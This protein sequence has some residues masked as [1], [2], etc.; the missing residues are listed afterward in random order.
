MM[1]SV[2]ALLAAPITALQATNPRTSNPFEADK[3]LLMQA[4]RACRMHQGAVYFIQHSRLD[5]PMIHT[6]RALGDTDAQINCVLQRLP[7]HFI[8][9][10][11]VD[12][13][14]APPPPKAREAA[15]DEQGRRGLHR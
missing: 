13:E 2:L 6:T 15:V 10:Y 4:S 12:A 3:V 9:R 8:A 5:A 7:G 14:A 11:R 1:G